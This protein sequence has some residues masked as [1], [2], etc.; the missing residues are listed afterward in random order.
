MVLTGV[1]LLVQEAVDGLIRQMS[2]LRRRAAACALTRCTATTWTA[3]CA[4]VA[5]PAALRQA[6]TRGH[7]HACSHS[8]DCMEQPPL[9]QPGKPVCEATRM[10][11]H[12][13][14]ITWRG[15]QMTLSANREVHSASRPAFVHYLTPSQRA[16]G[17]KD[18]QALRPCIRM[19]TARREM[20]A[21][22]MGSRLEVPR[23]EFQS[24]SR[25]RSAQH[26]C[27]PSMEMH[28]CGMWH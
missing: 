1:C 18:R 24:L 26:P 15:K 5:T 27:S 23:K 13:V 25:L 17:T 6:C 22:G 20:R 8:D 9:W 14:T 21:G 10:P 11:A 2:D 12:I 28:T 7:S 3:A 4:A 19:V 16:V